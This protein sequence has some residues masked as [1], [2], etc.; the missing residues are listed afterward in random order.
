[1]TG[2]SRLLTLT[3]L[4][5]ALAA[6]ALA[7][8]AEE[9]ERRL[10]LK[11]VRE[12]RKQTAE[13]ASFNDELRAG[14]L[15][16]YDAAIGSLEAAT[17]FEAEAKDH[18]R[19]QAGVGR[20]IDA[21]RAEL[22]RPE[23]QP[24]VRLPDN[25]TVD[26][27]ESELERERARLSANRSA[28]RDLERLSDER[29]AARNELSRR[30]G[31]LDQR[32]ESINDELRATA[33]RDAHPELKSAARSRLLARR[34]AAVREIEA[35]RAKLGLLD[36]QGALLPWRTD[37]AQ[38]RVA[39]SEQLVTMLE[40][41]TLG[42]RHD[43][44]RKLLRQVVEQCDEAAQIDALQE[45][46]AETRQFAELLWGLDGL[47]VRSEETARAVARTRKNLSDFDR[48]IQLARRKYQAFGSRGSLQRWW[49]EIPDDFPK[50]G[51]IANLITELEQENPQVQ[52][53]LIQFEQQRSAARSLR[54][55]VLQDLEADEEAEVEPRLAHDL[56]DT[57]R[58]LLD[59]L[60]RSSGRYS[61]QLVEL[62]SVSRR[63]QNVEED[64]RAFLLEQLLWVRS[65]PKP[66]IPAAGDIG[67]GLAWLVSGSNLNAAAGAALD[68]FKRLPGRGVGFLVVFG[69][70]V[71]MRRR[72]RRRLEVLAEQVAAPETDSFRAT[73]EAF[74]YTVLLA[75]PLPLAMKLGSAVLAGAGPS[76]ALY[77]SSQALG[78]VAAIA[79]LFELAR[80][81][82]AP[83]GLAEA[84]FGW[85]ARVIRPIHRGL[86]WR[87]AIF[88]PL[89]YIAIEMGMAGMRLDSPTELQTYNNSLGRVAFILGLGIVGFSLLALFRPRKRE[90]DAG[91][92][93]GLAWLHRLYMYVY[94][95]VVLATLLPA[96]LA[97]IGYYIT[98][99]LLAYQM[100]RTIWLLTALLVAAEL[101]LRWRTVG[102]REA[103]E[104]SQEEAERP[105]VP[106]A[107]TQVRKLFRFAI[108][109]AGAI[110]LYGI[111][112]DAI[113]TLEIMKRVQVWP[114]VV[115]MEPSDSDGATKLAVSASEEVAPAR[116]APEGEPGSPPVMP[117]V[118]LP[119]APGSGGA[120]ESS[121]SL[122]LTL[123][124]LLE[125]VLAAM[126]TTVLVKN[127]P[128]LL[129]LTLHKRT[130]LDRG[131][132]VALS[133]LVRYTIMIL[134]V[135]IAFGLLGISW[136]K[137]QWLA[138]ALT[139]GLGFGLQEIVANFV[140]GLILLTERPI[141]VGD[142]VTVGNLQGLVSRI[143]IRA[144]TITL[145]DRS[146]MIVPN[147]EFIT[148]KLVNWTLSDSK[149]R[150]D[151]PLRVAYGADLEKVKK[152]LIEVARSHPD[153][154]DDPPPQALLLEFGE[155]ALKF[156]LRYFVDFGMGLRTRD[157]LHMK[158]DRAFREN[159]IDF[160][161]PKLDIRIPRRSEG[162]TP[163]RPEPPTERSRE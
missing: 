159:G 18:E 141:R 83:H 163:P 78:Y 26:R 118:P 20:M 105:D 84:H 8:T 65:V 51:E 114:R 9:P 130:R 58:D 123:W 10:D 12:L 74:L 54:A 21:L 56:L 13:N 1:M 119:A 80:Q 151:I 49:P 75:S 29:A 33:Q 23:E 14:V 35:V 146:E 95:A 108:V 79:A 19:E 32:I 68:V 147:K 125:A 104:A 133:T 87:E 48:I 115:L 155:D 85:P 27:A 15:E 97:A 66:I 162:Q 38:R 2:R 25:A 17:A 138:A 64:V 47:E 122:P 4:F 57:R 37:Q 39:Y 113:P 94:P 30:L 160:A 140:S 53:D 137:I 46:A 41:A 158:V 71:G 136:S 67:H 116:A 44:A 96:V 92:D 102:L 135:S 60:I 127:L 139:F 42:L 81:A 112:A 150:I 99:Y 59:E 28:L 106:V 126:I 134:G 89:I 52:H 76:P 154:F 61:N 124:H 31:G 88:L 69:L 156:E 86:L 5:A 73:M 128:G 43:E 131:A 16:Q 77:S 70:L 6:P 82:L 93:P 98:G 129:E 62:E 11:E 34:E 3:L 36:A 144:T 153:V 143:Q 145:W 72:M 55:K 117:G 7:Q 101:L 103:A 110:G 40:E 121:E 157:E 22:E 45:V 100:L 142:A 161:L 148:T 24:R 152:T 50:P 120:A 90:A 111:W 149:R 132:R 91:R 109:L 63:F 107:E